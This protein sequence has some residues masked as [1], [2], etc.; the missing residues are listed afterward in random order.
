[1]ERQIILQWTTAGEW[2]DGSIN[3]SERPQNTQK[4]KKTGIACRITC[5]DWHCSASS[6]VCQ[7]E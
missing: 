6:N 7:H 1:M 5:V 3:Q 4:L 2:K